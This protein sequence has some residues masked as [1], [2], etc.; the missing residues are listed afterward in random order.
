MSAQAMITLARSQVGYRE[1]GNNDTK[2]NR[3]LGRI[4]G[5]PHDGYGYPWCHAFLSWLLAQTGNAGAGPRTAGCEVGVGWFRTRG[6][7]HNT[8]KVG[9]FVYYGAGGGTHVELVIGVSSSSITTIGGNTS[10]ALNGAYYNGNG[11]YLKSVS[12]SSTR[13]HGYGRPDYT[14]TGTGSGNTTWEDQLIGLKKGDKGEA[15]KAIQEMVAH[16]GFRKALGSD[17]VDGDYGSSTAEGVRLA[18]A[19]VGSKAE[20]GYGDKITGIAMGQLIS[21]V[22]KRQAEEAKGGSAAVP[23]NLTVD[24]V[25]TKRLVVNG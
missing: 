11:V 22:A 4:P 25:T 6:R 21:A 18:R 15:V 8:P 9:D 14:A 17:G 1:T 10:G 3:W 24:S 13:I 23:K 19:Y 12:R 2:Y 7:Y 16:A 5:Y 20:K